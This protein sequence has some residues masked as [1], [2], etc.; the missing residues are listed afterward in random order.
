ME[1]ARGPALKKVEPDY[2]YDQKALVSKQKK[3]K[4]IL[5]KCILDKNIE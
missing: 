4:L 3:L 1:L 5:Q 2:A